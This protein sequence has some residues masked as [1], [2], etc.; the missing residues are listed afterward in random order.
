MLLDVLLVA[1]ADLYIL[2]GIVGMQGNGPAGGDPVDLGVLFA[3]I[4][5]VAMDLAVCSMLGIEP[6]GIPILKRAKIRGLWPSSIS[7]PLL[8]PG[9]V[10][11]KEFQLPSTAGYLLTG[12]KIPVQMPVPLESCVACGMCE[13]ICPV[14][15]IC[16]TDEIAVV[17]FQRCI[18]CYCCHEVC[19]YKAIALEKR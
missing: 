9:E 2:D 11:F 19:P 1:P 13:E 7:Y 4:D 17:D 3:G 14:N 5:P 16:T 10:D 6:M 12:K 15:A 18:R 8:T